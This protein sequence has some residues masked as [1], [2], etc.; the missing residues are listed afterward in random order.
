M[1]PIAARGIKIDVAD[2]KAFGR[3]ATPSDVL[4]QIL[5]EGLV[6][7]GLAYLL[8]LAV[9]GI[10]V[11]AVLLS[12]RPPVTQRL[13]VAFTP[14]M[15]AGAAFHVLYQL[16]A[17]ADA[18]AP[19]FSAPTVY[20]TTFLVAGA[21]WA[22]LILADR[23][24][25]LALAATGGVATLAGAALV[26]QTATARGTFA[27][28]LPVAALIVSVVVAVVTYAVL[29]RIRPTVTARTGT[30]GVV[31]VFGHAL[32]GVSTAVG[33]DLLGSGERSPIPAA[34][35]EFAGSLPTAS[36]VGK[37]WLFVL[38]KLLI[39]AAVVVLFA[40]FVEEDPAQGN[41]ALGVV[42]AVG[43]GPGTHNLLLFAAAGLF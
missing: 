6:V 24:V 5:P 25:P 32:D 10:A 30:L 36:V 31:V 8:G 39:A 37:G 16:D 38:V 21:V 28:A 27:P 23:R 34:I 1:G 20:A 17:V 12:R 14:W 42:A 22:G 26:V 33:V 19:L 41:A 18:I 43:L 9:A 29:D 2:R 11:G 40:D 35:M 7:P 15:A 3:R 4:L 13:V